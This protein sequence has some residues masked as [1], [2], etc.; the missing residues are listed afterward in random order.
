MSMRDTDRALVQA[1][2]AVAKL[3]CRS[4]NHTVA[5]AAR[6]SDGRVFTG[7]NVYHFTG[8]PCAELVTI[9]AAATQ[10][11]TELETI[12]A[13]GDRGRGVIPPCGRCRQVLRDYFPSIRVI[14]G[15]MDAL[16][17]VEVGDLLPDTYVWADHQV[18]DPAVPAAR[19]GA[20][21]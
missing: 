13:V 12:V 16:R 11:A 2:T 6:T 5:A 7:V 3:R 21:G 18:D 14:V 17:V 15:P 19:G 10:G 9:G 4:E 20:E 1:A 8:G